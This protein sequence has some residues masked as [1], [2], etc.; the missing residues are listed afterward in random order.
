MVI[1]GE[2]DPFFGAQRSAKA[3]A[4]KRDKI[5]KPKMDERFAVFQGKKSFREVISK[6]IGSGS[7]DL[8]N[9]GPQ[10]MVILKIC[11]LVVGAL[12]AMNFIFPNYW[13]SNHPN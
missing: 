3:G 10:Q 6:R 7:D 13:V 2:V 9:G 8:M 4:T 12:V 5:Y 11:Q 1:L